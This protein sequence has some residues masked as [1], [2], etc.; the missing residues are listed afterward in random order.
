MVPCGSVAHAYTRMIEQSHGLKHEV[1][2]QCIYVCIIILFRMICVHVCV[3]YMYVHVYTCLP[4][5]LATSIR[6][7][8]NCSPFTLADRAFRRVQTAMTPFSSSSS[9][10]PSLASVEDSLA[11][12]SVMTAL[13][14]NSAKHSTV[15]GPCSSICLEHTALST[16]EQR[17]CWYCAVLCTSD[18]AGTLFLSMSISSSRAAL[19]SRSTASSEPKI[20]SGQRSISVQT[21]ERTAQMI[22]R[23]V[24]MTDRVNTLRSNHNYM[25]LCDARA[26]ASAAIDR[27]IARTC[28]Y[29]RMYIYIYIYIVDRCVDART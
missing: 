9:R 22:T 27:S 29:V 23:P 16:S 7:I 28:T 12:S 2:V 14:E 19:L 6:L 21:T 1:Y 10:Q 25:R 20:T 18:S 13:M 4:V 26:G 8:I 17:S 15:S 5:A 11:W 3:L 24:I